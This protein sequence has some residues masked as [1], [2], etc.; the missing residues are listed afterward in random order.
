MTS[1]WGY[2][3]LTDEIWL[4]GGQHGRH[5]TAGARGGA[6]G[7]GDAAIDKIMPPSENAQASTTHTYLDGRENISG[8]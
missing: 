6:L 7:G 4:T 1:K 8:L 3:S 5:D 2:T